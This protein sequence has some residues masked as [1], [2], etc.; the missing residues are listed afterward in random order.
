MSSCLAITTTESPGLQ[1]ARGSSRGRDRTGSFRALNQNLGW[2]LAYNL[3]GIPV[4]AGVLLPEYGISLNPA[5]AGAMMALSSVAVVTNS[6]LLKV[7]GG[8]ERAGAP[9]DGLIKDPVPARCQ[10]VDMRHHKN[11]LNGNLLTFTLH[12]NTTELM[13]LLALLYISRTHNGQTATGPSRSRLAVPSNFV[14][15]GSSL[16]SQSLLPSR[17]SITSKLG[18]FSPNSGAKMPLRKPYIMPSSGR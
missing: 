8:V 17:A 12:L 3:V 14:P 15:T 13:I 10:P 9:G 5:A 4:A 16:S 2:A 1:A 18:D 11:F 7:P 6:L